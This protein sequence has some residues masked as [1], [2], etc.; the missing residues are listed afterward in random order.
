MTMLLHA[1][2]FAWLFAF[3]I[4]AG[5]LA[6]LMVHALTGG[7]WGS[8]VRTPLAA[9]TRAMPWISLLFLPVLL[10]VSRIYPWTTEPGPWLNTP[11]F[12]ARAAAY[13]AIWNLLAWRVLRGGEHAHRWAAG[14]LVAYGVLVT[15]A[16][17][18]WIAS[19][20]PHWYSSGFGLIVGTGQMLAGAAFAIVVASFATTRRMPAHSNETLKP[21]YLH[22]TPFQDLGNIL[23]VYVLAWAYLAYMQFLIIWSENLPREIAWY[24]PR[25]HGAWGALGAGII[26]FHF[27]LPVLILL[28]RTAKRSPRW[29]GTIAAV[30]LVGNAA[31]IFWMVMPGG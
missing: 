1:W 3:G 22:P 13:L 24:V 21:E 31:H 14:G 6:N 8:A 28:S 10:G 20:M 2:L 17:F 25:V 18:D 19:L 5:A 7:A 29:L 23:L 27:A 30:V 4:S 15:L 9:A 12:V 11:F 16:A 26:A